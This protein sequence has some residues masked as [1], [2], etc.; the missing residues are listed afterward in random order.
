M[1]KSYSRLGR[2]SSSFSSC[3]YSL[4]G[5]AIFLA[6]D[7]SAPLLLLALSEAPG[8]GVEVAV[9][10]A[11]AVDRA[12]AGPTECG[13]PGVSTLGMATYGEYACRNQTN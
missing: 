8:A 4:V 10:V 3:S 7:V 6:P 1:L 11:A 5:K 9:V 2:P 13:Q 12:G